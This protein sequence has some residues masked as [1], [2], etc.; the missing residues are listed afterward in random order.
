MPEPFGE[1]TSQFLSVFFGPE[2]RL[3][4]A[5]CY[6]PG[7]PGARFAPWIDR[8]RGAN[9][10]PT[11]LPRRR[12][13][14]D[15]EW[16]G[17]AFDERQA[18][19][20]GDDLMAF[21]G[22][23][24]STFR[25]RRGSLRSDDPIDRAVERFTDGR[26][27]VFANPSRPGEVW[28]ALEQMRESWQQRPTLTADTSRSVGRVLRNFHMALR[29]GDRAEAEEQLAY[30][31]GRGLLSV[32]NRIFLRVQMLWTLGEMQELLALPI[33]LDVLRAR[34]PIAV[35]QAL[36]DAVYTVELAEFE[37]AGDPNRAVEK[38]RTIILPRFAPLYAAFSG[39][40]STAAAKSFLLL[41]VAGP[42]P[43]PQLRDALLKFPWSAEAEASYA[44]ELAKQLPATA[45]KPMVDALEAA[46]EAFD[47][48]DVGSALQL[49]R[50]ASPSLSRAHVLSRCA[51]EIGSIEA[52]AYAVE[53]VRALSADE[54]GAFRSTWFG[55]DFFESFVS[56]QPV[57]TGTGSAQS[58]G[59]AQVS[60]EPPADWA[61]WLARLATSGDYP[62]ALEFARRGATEWAAATLLAINDGATGAAHLLTHL[63][64]SAD[65]VF[66]E[67]IPHL[68][69]AL[70]ADPEWP[71]A[72]LGRVY[73][74]VGTAVALSTSGGVGDFATFVELFG[75]VLHVGT[76]PNEYTDLLSEAAMLC[77]HYGAPATFDLMLD[78]LETVVVYPCASVPA[79][80]RLLDAADAA[81][82]RHVRRLRPEQRWLLERLHVDLDAQTVFD[83]LLAAPP[84]ERAEVEVDP[85]AVLEGSSVAIYT[86]ND[87]AAQ[88][89]RELLVQRV[90]NVT[91]H[92]SNDQAG[93]TRLRDLARNADIFVMSIGSAL[94]AATTFI[95]Q[96]RPSGKPL[97]KTTR[98][99]KGSS[100]LI[101]ALAKYAEQR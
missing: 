14:D 65:A 85:L 72:E 82:S 75:A 90:P 61:D 31:E 10:A 11:V 13:H 16:Y 34:R 70:Q 62:R 36:I 68:V 26:A 81:F 99:S 91:V 49:A 58:A 35:T 96:H 27:F 101:A 66:A 18:R 8:L 52:E 86:L 46:R 94:H 63:P 20:L 33:L 25:G 89:T 44:R 1:A 53:A 54:L 95:E 88:V 51:Y 23:S 100:G 30:I 45:P 59:I 28:A 29:G 32:I 12:S 71:R 55:R 24:Y 60:Q 6:E 79:R 78:L 48:G 98:R 73:R 77:D 67:A 97:L 80:S 41:S 2:N 40:T 92:V 19:A 4:L 69:A 64:P 74:A 93:T 56:P 83:N 22:P 42:M 9:P 37:R 87:R 7:A 50:D 76:A 47:R 5:A 39:L 84:R 38:F 43:N 17:L 15:F 57:L 3:T 21:V